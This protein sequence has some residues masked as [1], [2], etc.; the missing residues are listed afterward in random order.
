MLI[1][2]T[3]PLLY[4]LHHYFDSSPKYSREWDQ[5]S[6]LDFGWQSDRE[7]GNRVVQRE[8]CRLVRHFP[9]EITTGL[10]TQTESWQG[11]WL[12]LFIFILVLMFSSRTMRRIVLPSRCPSKDSDD[13]LFTVGKRRKLHHMSVDFKLKVGIKYEKL[14][15]PLW[16][17]SCMPITT[18]TCYIGEGNRQSWK[19]NLE[20]RRIT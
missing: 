13:C 18:R 17:A 15:V 7:R 12:T 1:R 4:S 14:G 6:R 10:I 2:I 20:W 9:F 5:S 19:W 8:I 16:R 11:K 3:F